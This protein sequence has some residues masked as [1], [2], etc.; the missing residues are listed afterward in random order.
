M[1]FSLQQK[2]QRE[3]YQE[4]LEILGSLS[5]LFSSSNI[6]FLYYRVAE[7]LFCESFK[8]EDLSRNDVSADAKK[9]GLGIGLKTFID[10]NSKS[11]QKVA[12][13]NLS[14]LGPNPTPKKIAELRNAR[15]DFTE[16]VHGLS[17][18][19]YHCILREP[20]RFKI[21]EET[22]N[23]IDISRI[24]NIKKNKGSIYFNDGVDEYSFLLSK[25]TL[26]KRF[27]TNIIVH[28]F[29]VQILSNP[30]EELKSLLSNRNFFADLKDDKL[31]TSR[32][33][34]TNKEIFLPLYGNNKTVYNKSGLNQWNAGGRKRHPDEVYIP[35]PVEIHDLFPNFFP[36]RD[37]LFSLKFPDGEILNASVCQQGSKALMTKSNRKLG[38][39][40]LRDGLMLKEG[41]LA[42]FEKLQLLGI[43]SVRIQKN[44]ETN[45][46]IDFARCGSFESFILNSRNT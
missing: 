26:T 44:N 34:S 7:T 27:T 20:N 12:E 36:S 32:S 9:D 24:D 45:Y 4:N 31:E 33:K 23:K 37:I 25:S 13:F 35:I 18:S 5:N 3:V 11:F 21:F 38:K 42:T 2:R 43:D 39:L 40:I 16:K 46:E 22:M 29:E 17:K 8:A 19:I 28:E 6:P 10:G 15:I 1:F 14:N 41:E 30:L